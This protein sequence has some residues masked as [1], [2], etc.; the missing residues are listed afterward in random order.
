MIFFCHSI[1]ANYRFQNISKLLQN[2]FEQ[3]VVF[4]Q[5]NAI[6]LVLK[7]VNDKGSITIAL[8]QNASVSLV[9]SYFVQDAREKTILEINKIIDSIITNETS[10]T[11]EIIVVDADGFEYSYLPSE[12]IPGEDLPLENIPFNPVKEGAPRKKETKK[13]TKE[14]SEKV[15]DLHSH[16]ISPVS[17][18]GWTNFQILTLQLNT[19][20]RALDK[21]RGSGINK[22]ILIALSKLLRSISQDIQQ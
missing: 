6:N 9:P 11:Y 22:L 7:E 13:N 5:Q 21:S 14:R 4:G 2:S 12:L 15:V 8:P 1:S 16:E 20:K 18:K 10:I 19:A 17:T 3:G